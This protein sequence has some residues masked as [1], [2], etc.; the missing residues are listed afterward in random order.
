MLKLK[1][2]YFGHLM[3]RAD[4]VE[5][6]LMLGKTESRRRRG[7]Q[8]MSCLD[9]ITD[10]RDMNLHKLHEMVKDGKA[11]HAAF[12]GVIKS[13]TR[14]SD[15]KTMLPP[16]FQKGCNWF[17]LADGFPEK[18][19]I[20]SCT[21]WYFPKFVICQHPWEHSFHFLKI[22]AFWNYPQGRLEGKLAII[23]SNTSPK[24]DYRDLPH[25]SWVTYVFETFL[26]S[27]KLPKFASKNHV[28]KNQNMPPPDVNPFFQLS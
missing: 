22:T 27:L 21:F 17:L 1:L 16:I 20:T 8:R 9:S 26:F 11:W 7:W 3:E 12:H 28:I 25:I 24:S 14:L 23:L 2:Q 15:L 18:A 6:T 5:N 13:Q 10:S 19:V 4:S